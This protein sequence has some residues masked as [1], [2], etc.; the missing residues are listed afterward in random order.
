[1]IKPI[2][3]S[4]SP[5]D[6]TKDFTIKFTYSYSQIFGRHVIIRDNT[7]NE[8]V[9]EYNTDATTEDRMKQEHIIV[10]GT[11]QNGKVYN[12]SISVYDVKGNES[13][14]SNVVV[15]SCYTTP[16][17]KFTNIEQNDI[18][19][20]SNYSFK[21]TYSQA[22]DITI[23]SYTIELYDFTR[24]NLLY[25]TGTMYDNA[26]A[27]TI[28]GLT[29]NESYYIYAK[30]ETINNIFIETDYIYFTV[31][32]VSPEVFTLLNLENIPEEGSVKLDSHFVLVEGHSDDELFFEDGSINLTNE[33]TVVFNE[34]FE[35]NN[36]YSI[37]GIL[38][39]I[40][41]P[42]A[43]M[44]ISNGINEIK[45]H[46]YVGDFGAGNENY[47]ELNIETKISPTKSYKYITLSN[48]I[49]LLADNE[50]A[51]FLMQKIDGCFNLQLGK[52]A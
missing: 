19:G 50:Q 43:F 23:D 18:I 1:M 20:S 12:I 9:N 47:I 25:T 22:E 26:L 44:C 2:V 34:G 30:G 15:F 3:Y 33:K 29:D 41:S 46:W 7:T 39:N 51:T 48:R 35:L 38:S 8:V 28:N 6:A 31:D 40:Q 24:T 49:P 10:A 4:I 32:Y 14:E 45:L 42:T 11:L 37:A 36:K 13:A 16:L 52:V 17:F 27:A 5:F 21:L